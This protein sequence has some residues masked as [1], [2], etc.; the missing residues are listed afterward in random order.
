M[1]KRIAIPEIK[2]GPYLE[3]HGKH[4]RFI[5]ILSNDCRMFFSRLVMMRKLCTTSIP[6]ALI[7]HHIDGDTLNDTIEN[8]TLVKRNDHIRKHNINKEGM[9]HEEYKIVVTQRWREA[10][11]EHLRDYNKKAYVKYLKRVGRKEKRRRECENYRLRKERIN[12]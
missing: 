10:N 6:K 3:Q 8:L 12:G 1:A 2:W 9:S 4:K 5:V 7:V 11:R